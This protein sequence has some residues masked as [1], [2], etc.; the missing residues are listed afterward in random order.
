V[1]LESSLGST[2]GT[3][4]W[5]AAC[6]LNGDEQVSS[7]DL[8]ILDR[9]LVLPDLEDTLIVST[10][11]GTDVQIYM[12]DRETLA[13]LAG[14]INYEILARAAIRRPRRVAD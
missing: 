11:I 12:L 10:D 1:R 2:T 3:P 6:D 4:N 8:A 7:V 13:G 5:D 14:T 9:S